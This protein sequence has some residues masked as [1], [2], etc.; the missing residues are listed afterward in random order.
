MPETT[1]QPKEQLRNRKARNLITTGCLTVL[2]ASAVTLLA[3]AESKADS[4]GPPC[5]WEYE[6]GS[7]TCNCWC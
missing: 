4:C 1:D 7:W 3:P 2:A 6:N 5:F